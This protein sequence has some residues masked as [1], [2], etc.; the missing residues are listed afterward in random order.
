[1]DV[2]RCLSLASRV[3]EIPL[4]HLWYVVDLK[5]FVKLLPSLSFSSYWQTHV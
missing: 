3:Y 2:E 5:I 1:M 4:S